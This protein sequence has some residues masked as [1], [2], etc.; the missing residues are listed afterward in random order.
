MW[1]EEEFTTQLNNSNVKKA[2]D[3]YG[4]F[5]MKVTVNEHAVD[6]T[7]DGEKAFETLLAML[8]NLY[9]LT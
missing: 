6:L 7:Y 1:I 3:L 8:L 5:T 2:F 9:Q 4:D